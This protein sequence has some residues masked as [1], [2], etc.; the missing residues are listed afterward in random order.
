[1]PATLRL[2]DLHPLYRK[3]S[4]EEAVEIANLGALCYQATRESLYASWTA[5][6][7]EEEVARAEAYRK[8]GAEEMMDT[9]QARLAA[10]EAAKAR[11]AALQAEID[12]VVEERVA[13]SLEK[14]RMRLE[15]QRVAPLEKRLSALEGKDETIAL[16][17]QANELMQ[18]RCDGLVGE[19]EELKEAKTKSSHVI[20]KQGEA[21]VW[22][23][24][25]TAVLPEFPYAEAK[26]MAGVSHAA[27]FHLWIMAAN[28]RRVKFLIDSKKYKRAVSSDEIAK[29]AA[30]VDADEEA[31]AGLLVSLAS[32]ICT[33]RQFQMGLT[34]KQKPMLFLTF[35][36]ME[37]VLQRDTLCWG[38]R[39]LLGVVSANS[40]GHT[41]EAVLEN[42]EAFAAGVESS[43]GDM[44]AAIRLQMKAVDGMRDTRKKLLERLLTFKGGGDNDAIEHV[45][46]GCSAIVKATGARCGRRVVDGER[47]GNHRIRKH[48]G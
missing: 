7:S 29:L 19:L 46:E 14:E 20:G 5:A 31:T 48:D 2:E 43:V 36:E 4:H 23:M 41:R 9:L 15:L 32:P 47:C 18:K 37:S 22:E 16:L 26:N 11:V 1:M 17:K 25:E 28:G 10:G 45:G 8:E 39:V 34:P 24:I 38:L 13:G 33:M 3:V 27:D 21:T 35:M 30:D 40:S 12:A 44:D 6:Q 42:I